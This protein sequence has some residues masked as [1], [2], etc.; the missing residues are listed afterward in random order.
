MSE[1]KF[2]LLD[3]WQGDPESTGETYMRHRIPGMII[4]HAGT[5]IIYNEAR[6]DGSDW[7]LMDVFC[8]RSE[9]GGKTFG[10]PIYLVRGTEEHHT[11]N[12]PVMMQ[13]KNG[14]IH[15]IHGEDYGVQGGKVLRRYSDDDGLTWSEPIDITEFTMPWFR[16]CIAF[17]PGHGICLRNGTLLVPIWLVPKFYESPVRAHG[18]SM[19]STLYS[20]DNGETWAIGE[21]LGSNLELQSPNETAAVE[22]SDGR[23]YLSIRCNNAWRAKA[24]SLNG[25]S[26]WMEY[27]PE[28][29][30]HD[31]KCFGAVAAIKPEGKPYTILFANCESKTK[32]QNV[33]IKGS[34]DNG[35]TWTLRR[36]I[37]AERGGY[38]E[39]NADSRTGLIYVFYENKAGETDHLAIFNYEWL[40]EGEPNG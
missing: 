12:N 33:V 13:D 7:A 8:Q 40:E 10:E 9:D 6:R 30:L 39:V 1:A 23:V 26:G 36:V 19:V 11:T 34:V 28:K 21:L 32:R 35:K 15:F 5:V 25:Y 24:V 31:P 17:G 2:E 4:T 20:L 16:N 22:L 29:R 3:I 18:P 27:G 38:V 14:R 37:D